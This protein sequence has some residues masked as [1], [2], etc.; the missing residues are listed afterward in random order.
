MCRHS[1]AEIDANRTRL[2]S[3]RSSAERVLHV[4]RV[5]SVT[6][7]AGDPQTALL[8]GFCLAAS[9]AGVWPGQVDGRTGLQALPCW[10]LAGEHKWS[11]LSR[12]VVPLRDLTSTRDFCDIAVSEWCARIT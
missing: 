5:F 4:L 1:A 12:R 7:A 9:C 10:V 3:W 8:G 11:R 6:V 2:F